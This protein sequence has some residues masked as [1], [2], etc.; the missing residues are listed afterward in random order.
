MQFEGKVGS[1][2][3]LF[4]PKKLREALGLKPG[5][6]VRYKLVGKKLIV[7]PIPSI[8]DILTEDP[9]IVI[10]L[11]EFLAFRRKLSKVLED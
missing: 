3:E 2:G 5:V 7:E 9:K 10:D 1:K 11:K 4:I 8:E 6:K